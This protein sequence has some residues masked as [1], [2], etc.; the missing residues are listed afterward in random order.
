M[1]S[2]NDGAN[3]VIKGKQYIDNDDDRSANDRKLKL[4]KTVIGRFNEHTV[5]VCAKPQ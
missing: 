5:C 4:C 1:K 3:N 2:V